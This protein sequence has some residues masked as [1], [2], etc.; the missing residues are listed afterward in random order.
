[1]DDVLLYGKIQNIS[2][3]GNTFSEHDIKFRL[4]E[5][6]SD[7]IFYNFDT[8]VISD[9]NASL[10][11]G[12]YTADVQPDG[13]IEFKSPP[14][15]CGLRVSEHDADLFPELVYEYHAAVGL[16]DGRRQLPACLRHHSCLQAHMGIP[17][18]SVYLLSGDKGGHGVH[19]NDIHRAGAH[20]GLCN[21]QRLLAG[22][23]LR[24]IEIVHIDPDVPGIHRIQGMLCV[25]KACDAAALLHLCHHVQGDSGFSGG[26]RPVDLYNSSPRNSADTKRNIQSERACRYC[27]H[28]HLCGRISQLHDS[29]FSVLLFNLSERGIQCLHFF[30]TSH[31]QF[32]SNGRPAAD[33]GHTTAP[34]GEHMFRTNVRFGIIIPFFLIS[35]NMGSQR[36][37]PGELRMERQF[38]YTIFP[39]VSP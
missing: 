2:L 22:I 20:H 7:F 19:N 9:Y 17:H 14:S 6:R 34:P 29:T 13:S 31:N 24:D 39:A 11:Q 38:F 3:S 37:S 12:L 35:V 21:F 23:R 28:V 18:L 8:S 27:F 32:L 26:F 5:R 15:R 1:M 16:T 4:T 36:K 25:D 30:F 10:L 33:A